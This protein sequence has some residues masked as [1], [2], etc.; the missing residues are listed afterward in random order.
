MHTE[1]LRNVSAGQVVG[2]WLVAIAGTSLIVF[3]F[4]ASG[5]GAAEGAA[6]ALATIVAVVAGFLFGGFFAGFRARQAPSLHGVGIGFTS[7]VVWAVVNAIGAF[8]P[9][10]LYGGVGPIVVAALMFLQFGAAMFGALL[11]YN[12]AWR[13][14]P[15]IREDLEEN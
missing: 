3:V 9:E 7:V 6:N 14:K 13:G 10:L 2:G 5:F 1:H 11:G 12:V 4:L 8:R 15:G